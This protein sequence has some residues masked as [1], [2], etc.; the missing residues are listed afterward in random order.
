MSDCRFCADTKIVPGPVVSCPECQPK[1]I[2]IQAEVDRAHIIRRANHMDCVS[3]FMKGIGDEFS[4]DFKCGHGTA[5]GFLLALG[6]TAS[7]LTVIPT[8]H[9]PFSVVKDDRIDAEIKK[10]TKKPKR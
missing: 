3:I 6:I 1:Q 4:L 5:E 8:N 10:I 2:R 7:E 9:R